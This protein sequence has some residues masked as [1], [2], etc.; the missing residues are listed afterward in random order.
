MNRAAGQA[1]NGA[2]RWAAWM[3]LPVPLAGAARGQCRESDFP[4]RE[5]VVAAPIRPIQSNSPD[6][7][8]TGVLEATG[9]GA[10]GPA[11]FGGMTCGAKGLY[12]MRKN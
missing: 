8:Q 7:V 2:G 11:V 6:L 3:L 12:Q 9:P 10:P 4:G 1:W 5:G